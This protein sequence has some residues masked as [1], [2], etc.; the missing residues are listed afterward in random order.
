VGKREK[1]TIGLDKDS[2]RVKEVALDRVSGN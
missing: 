1:I 2:K